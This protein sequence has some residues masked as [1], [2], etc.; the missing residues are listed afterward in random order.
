M[1]NRNGVEGRTDK[2]ERFNQALEE[3]LADG[4]TR[5]EQLDA[6]EMVMLSI[7]EELARADLASLSKKK[8][9]LRKHLTATNYSTRKPHSGKLRWALG[10]V[11]VVVVM[12]TSLALLPQLRAWAQEVIAQVGHLLITDAPTYEEQIYEH[13]QTTTPQEGNVITSVPPSLEEV[14]ARVDFLVL[15]PRNFPESEE[16][17]IYAPPWAADRDMTW[18]SEA[19]F[20][21]AEGV[22]ITGIYKRWYSVYIHQ[23]KAPKDQSQEFPVSDA[24]MQEVIVRNQQGYWFEGVPKGLLESY[25]SIWPTD[26]IEPVWVLEHQNLLIWE[27]NGMVYI[28]QTDDELKLENLLAIADALS[29]D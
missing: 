10:L 13:L 28:I 19:V 29:E 2:I 17:D 9:T 22:T 21:Y 27:E 15:A 4:E 18:T 23:L 8:A 20:D 26:K 14:R 12:V 6:R 1:M 3:I 7:S 11:T 16:A 5:S 24:R 25:G